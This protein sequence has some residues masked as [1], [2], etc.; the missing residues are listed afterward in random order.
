MQHES[1]VSYRMEKVE[2]ELRRLTREVIDLKSRIPA[3]DT[4]TVTDLAAYLGVAQSTLYKP[5]NLPNFGK[6]DIGNSPRRW[7]RQ[8]A[9]AW[10]ERPEAERRQEWEAMSEL[11]AIIERASYR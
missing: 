2:V 3:K 1:D 5:W 7:M 8:K 4:V 6:P 9:L 10:Y 11:E